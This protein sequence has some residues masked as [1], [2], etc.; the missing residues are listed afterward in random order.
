MS[1]LQISILVVVFLLCIVSVFLF[2]IQKKK[3]TQIHLQNMQLCREG[4]SKNK[5]QIKC[6]QEYLKNY[7]FLRQ[8]VSESLHIQQEIDISC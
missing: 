8:N 7:D 3:E 6:R 5:L 4:I 2:W 1:I